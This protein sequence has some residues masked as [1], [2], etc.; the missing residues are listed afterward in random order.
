MNRLARANEI[1]KYDG[2]KN[3]V[4][5]AKTISPILLG[6]AKYFE[7]KKD[8]SKSDEYYDLANREVDKVQRFQPLINQKLVSEI[9]I[10]YPKTNQHSLP[11]N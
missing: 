5:R 4:E 3:P 8:I 10:I 6:F 9:K 1:L 11:E 7:N 2:F